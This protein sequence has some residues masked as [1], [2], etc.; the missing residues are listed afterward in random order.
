[1]IT[2]DPITRVLECELAKCLLTGHVLPLNVL[3]V[4]YTRAPFRRAEGE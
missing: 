4:V 1:M 2:G 3:V